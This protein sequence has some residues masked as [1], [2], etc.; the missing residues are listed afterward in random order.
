MDSVDPYAPP[1]AEIIPPVGDFGAEGDKLLCRNGAILPRRCIKTNAPVTERQMHTETVRWVRTGRLFAKS[2]TVTYGVN[3]RVWYRRTKLQLISKIFFWTAVAL[4][5]LSFLL[6]SAATGA[7]AL[8]VV[9]GALLLQSL[10]GK[11]LRVTGWR[12]SGEFVL[13]GCCQEFLD[14]L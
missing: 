10:A 2:L 7:L 3:P 1:S 8:V 11:T 4:L 5:V 13:G 12:R 14:S 9:V 6:S